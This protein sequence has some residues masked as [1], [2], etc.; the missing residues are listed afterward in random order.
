MT[1]Y[2]DGGMTLT[3]WGRGR[4]LFDIQT[5]GLQA[6]SGTATRMRFPYCSGGTT[7]P[8][9]I[10]LGSGQ[11]NGDQGV[12]DYFRSTIAHNTVEIDAKNQATIKGP[13]LWEKSYQTHCTRR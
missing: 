9:L 5:L 3:R 10:D 1:T 6:S 7:I 2:P 4:L 12:R 11:Y 8:V 13:F